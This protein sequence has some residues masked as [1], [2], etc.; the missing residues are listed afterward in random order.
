[1]LAN[2]DFLVAKIEKNEE[3]ENRKIEKVKCRMK[4]GSS[5]DFFLGWHYDKCA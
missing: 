3:L 2:F 4:K 5:N 1:M